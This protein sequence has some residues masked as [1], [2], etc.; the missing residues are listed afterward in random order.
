M[1]ANPRALTSQFHAAQSMAAQSDALA[2]LA[3]A[4]LDGLTAGPRA[5]EVAIAQAQVDIAQ[6]ALDQLVVQRQK[7]TLTA[8]ISG[9]VTSLSVRN[10]EN[11]QPGAKLMTVANLDNMRLTLYVPNTQVGRVQVGQRVLVTVDG[12]PGKTLEGRVYFISSRAEYTPAAVQ[13]KDERAK[14][15]FMI[16]VSMDNPAHTLKPGMAADA[17]VLE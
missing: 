9:M 6:A 1:R 5:E 14:M 11:V 8:P 2:L 17:V 10:G 3:R 15:V 4:E 7:M 16:K 12:L 13:T